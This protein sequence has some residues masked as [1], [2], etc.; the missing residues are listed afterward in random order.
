[1]RGLDFGVSIE[2]VQFLVGLDSEKF[3]SSTFSAGFDFKKILVNI[4]PHNKSCFDNYK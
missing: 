2:M 1:M 4:S 3:L